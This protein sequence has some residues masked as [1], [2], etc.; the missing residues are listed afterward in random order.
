MIL[1]P[2]PSSCRLCITLYVFV[3]EVYLEWMENFFFYDEFTIFEHLNP[4]TCR[5]DLLPRLSSFRD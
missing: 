4:G 3:R 2:D 1:L 5:W